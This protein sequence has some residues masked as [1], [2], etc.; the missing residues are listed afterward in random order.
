MRQVSS[1][2]TTR[3]SPSSIR[4]SQFKE[5]LPC[6]DSS[7]FFLPLSSPSPLTPHPIPLTPFPLP[8]TSHPSPP[9]LSLL[10]LAHHR[11]LTQSPSPPLFSHSSPTFPRTRSF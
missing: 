6:V 2:P 1:S 10:P 9:R 3:V 5:T 7:P 8:L 4:P 11:S